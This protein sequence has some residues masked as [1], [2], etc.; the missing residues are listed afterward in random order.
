MK[1]SDKIDKILY[2]IENPHECIEIVKSID[3]AEALY[4]LLD[5]YKFKGLLLKNRMNMD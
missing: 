2:E 5:H 3:T 4:T 1:T